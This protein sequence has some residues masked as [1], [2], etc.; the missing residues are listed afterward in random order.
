MIYRV[1]YHIN[2]SSHEPQ[3]HIEYLSVQD[4]T[5]DHERTLVLYGWSKY[6]SAKEHYSD[7]AWFKCTYELVPEAGLCT[8]ITRYSVTECLKLAR[9]IK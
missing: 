4:S 6:G 2:H 1:E 5:F 7:P 3:R 8:E 9:Q